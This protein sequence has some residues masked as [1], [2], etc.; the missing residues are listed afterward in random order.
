MI[1]KRVAD[2]ALVGNFLFETL[3]VIIDLYNINRTQRALSDW[4]ETHF[5]YQSIELGKKLF[6]CFTRV[7][8][9]SKSN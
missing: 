3:V 2:T 1:Y 6:Y 5:F 8:Y 4:S 7:K 9:I